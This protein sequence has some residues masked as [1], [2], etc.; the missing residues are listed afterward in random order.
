MFCDMASGTV[1]VKEEGKQQ[2]IRSDQIRSG[3]VRSG[4]VK[5]DHVRSFKSG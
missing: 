5:I 1:M 4:Q 3:Q 2:Q